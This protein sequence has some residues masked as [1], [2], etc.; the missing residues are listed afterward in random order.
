MY[1]TKFLL[2]WLTVYF[3]FLLYGNK[4]SYSLYMNTNN[5]Y[6]YIIY[7]PLI[8]LTKINSFSRLTILIINGV[9]NLEKNITDVA[10]NTHLLT[11]LMV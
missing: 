2:P 9:I 11:L 7:C 3:R 6:L 1:A 10:E 8:Q 5:V 4:G